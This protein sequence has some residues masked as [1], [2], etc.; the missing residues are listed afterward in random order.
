MQTPEVHAFIV[1]VG[2]LKLTITFPEIDLKIK[3]TQT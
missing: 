2:K 1:S 3:N